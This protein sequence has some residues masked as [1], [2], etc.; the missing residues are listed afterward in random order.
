MAEIIQAEPKRKIWPKS[1][2]EA[3]QE[4]I[5]KEE[6]AAKVEFE[7]LMQ[8]FGKKFNVQVLPKVV[9]SFSIEGITHE[10]SNFQ[11]VSNRRFQK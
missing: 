10:H 8:E 9:F 1:K 5:D 4:L 3:K 2:Q 7:K 6:A 11:I